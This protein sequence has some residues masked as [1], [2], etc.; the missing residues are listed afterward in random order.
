MYEP[1]IELI[2]IADELSNLLTE[3]N[4][5]T[6][7]EKLKFIADKAQELNSS[8]SQSYIGYHSKVYYD[9]FAIP[10]EGTRFSSE[11]GFGERFGS[12][13]T[14]G[15]WREFTVEEVKSEIQTRCGNLVLSDIELDIAGVIETF[16][17]CKAEI[18]SIISSLDSKKDSFL[19]SIIDRLKELDLPTKTELISRIDIPQ[20]LTRDS[21]AL[22]GGM[23]IPPH[24]SVVLDVQMLINPILYCEELERLAR[25]AGSHILRKARNSLA[26]KVIG[27]NVFIG[28]G[29]S[30]LWR[31][32]KDFIVERLKLPIDEFNRVPV[33]GVTNI[34]RLSQMLDESAIAFLVM[35]AEDEQSDGEHHA[36][37]NVIHEAGLFQGRL[38]FSR[39]IV[40]LEDGCKEFSNI[41][42]LGQLRFPRGNI[43]ACFDDVRLVLEREELIKI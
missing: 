20:A 28:H 36:R 39:A 24:K 23:Q 13:G 40:L 9:G 25:R 41:Q 37:M 32:L 26:A 6:I 29:R 2:K 33:A 31:E 30:L 10:P 1:Q 14:K 35:T 19:E 42:G 15:D 5:A 17:H 8:W 7:K 4:S 12:Y 38:G 34:A 11:W 18:S 3:H 21:A 22:N 27:T 16:E 43:R